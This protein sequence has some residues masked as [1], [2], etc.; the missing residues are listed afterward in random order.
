MLKCE[1]LRRRNERN[2][3]E[4]RVVVRHLSK[5]K[6]INIVLLWKH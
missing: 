3:R 1:N 6:A 4:P 2:I 5:I